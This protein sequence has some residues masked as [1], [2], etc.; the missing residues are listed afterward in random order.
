MIICAKNYENVPKVEK[1]V[2][3]DEKLYKILQKA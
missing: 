3:K 2:P 1:W